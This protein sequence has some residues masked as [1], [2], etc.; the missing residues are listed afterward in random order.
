M[1]CRDVT[2]S[3]QS[4]LAPAERRLTVFRVAV[5]RGDVECVGQLVDDRLWDVDAGRRRGDMY[6]IVGEVD[7]VRD[8]VAEEEGGKNS[9]APA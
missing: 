4:T 6:G 2:A 8:E 3:L 9:D 5:L 7:E 1:R